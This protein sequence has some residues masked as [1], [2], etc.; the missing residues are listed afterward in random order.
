[1]ITDHRRDACATYKG[2]LRFHTGTKE[3]VL[4]SVHPGVTI[5]EVLAHTGWP[6]AVSEDW[7]SR[8]APTDE[9]LKI[10]RTLD[11][12]GFWV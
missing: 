6:L 9:E 3:A 8:P 12:A 2:I 5:A 4:A 11:P 1:M 7:R 10:I